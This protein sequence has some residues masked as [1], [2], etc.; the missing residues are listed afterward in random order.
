LLIFSQQEIGNQVAGKH[1]KDVDTKRAVAP[2][3]LQGNMLPLYEVAEDDRVIEIARKPSSK[4]IRCMLTT[5]GLP[6]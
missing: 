5:K 4:G 1:E 6:L 2:E 3:H